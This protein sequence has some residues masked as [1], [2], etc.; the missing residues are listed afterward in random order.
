MNIGFLVCFNEIFYHVFPPPPSLIISSNLHDS[1]IH[2]GVKTVPLVFIFLLNQLI[3][4]RNAERSSQ[5][6]RK[7]IGW[8]FR[9][10]PDAPEAWIHAICHRQRNSSHTPSSC[11]VKVCVSSFI[12]VSLR[13]T[14][15]CDVTTK[16]NQTIHDIC[17]KVTF[18]PRNIQKIR[19]ETRHSCC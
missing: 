15:G 14:S 2:D 1:D 10:P 11:K 6:P 8:P 9:P 4:E 7:V 12:Q 19:A 16:W 18:L 13:I 17:S 5:R 3:T